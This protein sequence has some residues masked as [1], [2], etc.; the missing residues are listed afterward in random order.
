MQDVDLALVFLFDGSASV[1]F[2]SFG[3]IASG[4]AAGLRDRDVAAALLGGAHGGF[5]G[6]LMLFSGP[7]D[8]ELLVDWTRIATPDALADFAQSVEDVP[9]AVQAG[10]TAIGEAL[11]ACEALLRAQPARAAR[12]VIDVAGDGRN[13]TGRPCGP[14]RDRLVDAGVTINGL[15]VLHEEPDLVESYTSEVIG[16]AGAF[17]VQCADYAGF[18]VAMRQKLL[19]EVA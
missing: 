10:T 11:V 18:A 8:Q 2:E 9:R 16:G 3:L 19:Q 4:T 1:T 12:Q 15:C 13:N 14:V 17:A 7:N 5:L 6:A